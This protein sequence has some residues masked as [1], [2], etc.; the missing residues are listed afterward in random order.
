MAK[1]RHLAITSG[2]PGKTA[3][4]FKEVLPGS[5]EQGLIRKPITVEDVYHSTTLDT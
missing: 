5:L 3:A 2:D 1:L 4:F